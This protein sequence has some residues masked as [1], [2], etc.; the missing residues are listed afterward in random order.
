MKIDIKKLPTFTIFTPASVLDFVN[1]TSY[2]TLYY[3]R[4][5]LYL[6]SGLSAKQG[7]KLGDR[8]SARAIFRENKPHLVHQDFFKVPL[9][10]ILLREFL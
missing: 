10:S 5:Y 9:F 8:S 4:L 1:I 7:R 3:E 2:V 6:K